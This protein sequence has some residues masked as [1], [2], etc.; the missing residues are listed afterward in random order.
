MH[1]WSYHL[2][3]L[4]LGPYPQTNPRQ[5]SSKYKLQLAVYT[6]RAR[7]LAC[8]TNQT[9]AGSL[10][11]RTGYRAHFS[12]EQS[13]GHAKNS[14]VLLVLDPSCRL[15]L[16]RPAEPCARLKEQHTA[17]QPQPKKLAWV[18]PKLLQLLTT[19]CFPLGAVLVKNPHLGLKGCRGLG[20]QSVRVGFIFLLKQAIIPQPCAMR[21]CWQTSAIR[22]CLLAGPTYCSFGLG[23]GIDLKR[24]FCLKMR[25]GQS[26]WQTWPLKKRYGERTGKQLLQ[27]ARLLLTPN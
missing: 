17:P 26:S 2:A 15:C 12:C 25:N 20:S 11:S 10:F 18:W 6:Q 1:C 16:G 27:K 24:Q 21:G 22:P 19:A 4:L 5:M 7:C 23:E 3:T 13:Q 8:V 14:P 9:S